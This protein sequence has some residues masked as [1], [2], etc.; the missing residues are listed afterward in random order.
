MPFSLVG[1]PPFSV[2]RARVGGYW[3][4]WCGLGP[5]ACPLA[6]LSRLPC[7]FRFPASSSST[8]IASPALHLDLG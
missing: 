2:L 1:F 5:R 8:T 3:V 7:S 4:A 6:K